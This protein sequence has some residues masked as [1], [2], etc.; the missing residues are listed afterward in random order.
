[1]I[2]IANVEAARAGLVALKIVE[3]VG[4]CQT[5]RRRWAV[6]GMMQASLGKEIR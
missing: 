6:L 4:F 1:M 2:R 5:G 3:D